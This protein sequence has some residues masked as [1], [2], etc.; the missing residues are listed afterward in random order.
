AGSE[1]PE[2]DADGEGGLEVAVVRFTQAENIRT[3]QDDERLEQ[4]AK[5]KE[6]GIAEDGKKEHTVAVNVTD[7][8]PDIHDKIRPIGLS[9]VYGGQARHGQTGQESGE[10]KAE[11]EQAGPMV[12]TAEAFRHDSRGHRAGDDGQKGGEFEHAVAPGKA[13]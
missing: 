3:V 11:Q 8:L 1:A 7:F 13:T 10:R 12:L 6:I 4:R 5:E 9:G 2:A